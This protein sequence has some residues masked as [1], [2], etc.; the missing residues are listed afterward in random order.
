M[1]LQ[2]GASS[3]LLE[4]TLSAVK[5][6]RE[7]A[8]FE[9]WVKGQRTGIIDRLSNIEAADKAQA[10]RTPLRGGAAAF[11]PGM[12]SQAPAGS[13][14]R[15]KRE[16]TA[17][18]AA[19]PAD[20]FVKK[21]NTD[22]Q[23]QRGL[24]LPAFG[25]SERAGDGSLKSLFQAVKSAPAQTLAADIKRDFEASKATEASGF[26]LPQLAVGIGAAGVGAGL[27]SALSGNNLLGRITNIIKS[28]S[29]GSG[30]SANAVPGLSTGVTTP[31]G[32]GLVGSGALNPATVGIAG[33]APLGASPLAV[34][35]G[36]QALPGVQ[37]LP[38]GGQIPGTNI[39]VGTPGTTSG[40]QSLLERVK[41]IAQRA[42]RGL[43]QGLPGD[44]PRGSA[45]SQLPG[46][47]AAQARAPALQP[48]V[49][50]VEPPTAP[51]L[52]EPVSLR[53]QAGRALLSSL[54]SGAPSANLTGL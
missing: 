50:S 9:A 26:G 39:Q 16:A 1:A 29:G 15:F 31:T 10:A 53:A 47:N 38:T 6:I 7:A 27:V 37:A 14:E 32:G 45:A 22:P 21:V 46:A 43:A 3:E 12:S 8:S 30:A 17:R 33:G 44:A 13:F 20:E 25:V 2:R 5:S 24:G 54:S 4:R 34:A 52:V 19:I 51:P 42:A 36:A 49:V 41:N 35:G 28:A 23:F 18:L 40:G 48:Q 11:A